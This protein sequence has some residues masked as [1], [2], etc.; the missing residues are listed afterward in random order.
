MVNKINMANTI[1]MANMKRSELI[2]LLIGEK[3]INWVIMV[4]V[5]DLITNIMAVVDANTQNLYRG[6]SLFV[7]LAS[8]IAFSLMIIIVITG[9]KLSRDLVLKFVDWP[10]IWMS[11]FFLLIILFGGL[12]EVCIDRLIQVPFMYTI[13]VINFVSSGMTLIWLANFKVHENLPIFRFEYIED[14]SDRL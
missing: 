5:V 10:F 6:N 4:F 13:A 1:N 9:W 2:N 11:C 7:Y 8:S 12:Y 3:S 14:N